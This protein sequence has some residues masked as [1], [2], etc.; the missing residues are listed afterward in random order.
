MNDEI[1]IY[2]FIIIIIYL[3]IFPHFYF[4]VLGGGEKKLENILK[5]REASGENQDLV[6][7]ILYPHSII[8]FHKKIFCVWK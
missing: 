4:L 8:R 1:F 6:S 2:S 3:F 7:L 5:G